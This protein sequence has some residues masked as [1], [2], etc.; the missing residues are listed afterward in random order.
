MHSLDSRQNGYSGGGG[1]T[2][3][4]GAPPRGGNDHN[5][6]LRLFTSNES[7][8][9]AYVRRL[10]PSR[11]DVDDLMQNV[12]VVLWAKFEQFE[13]G[14]D[15][16]AWAFGVARFEILAWLRDQGRRDRRI[17]ADDVVEMIA[18]ESAEAEG[19]F[20]RQR[21]ALEQCLSKLGGN[22]RELLLYVHQRG[23]SMREAVAQSGRT[24]AGFTQWLYR[25]RQSL[26]ECVRRE[27]AREAV[28]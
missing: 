24:S 19:V 9:R 2:F 20:S 16:R 28:S 7:A 8:I 27:V 18:D 3:V 26:L 25:M 14:R 5:R 11:A 22:Q 23:S 13:E 10:I 17:L 21:V 6:F 1:R 15:F 12:A 4:A